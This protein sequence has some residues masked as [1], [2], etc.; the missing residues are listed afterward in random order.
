MDPPPH[1]VV[2]TPQTPTTTLDADSSTINAEGGDIDTVMVVKSSGDP[3]DEETKDWRQL[4]RRSRALTEQEVLAGRVAAR[5]VGRGSSYIFDPVKSSFTARWDCIIAASVLYT[6][7][8]TPAEVAFIHATIRLNWL[9]ICNQIVNLAFIIDLGLQFFTSYQLPNDDW[10]RDHH[11]IAK[12]YLTSTFGFD[13]VAS[14]PYDIFV[15]VEGNAAP[16]L[17]HKVSAARLFRLVRLLK[18]LRLVRSS[19]LLKKY[20]ADLTLSYGFLNVSFFM[21]ISILMAHWIACAWGL[22]GNTA[23]SMENSWLG[24]FIRPDDDKDASP[25]NQWSIHVPKNQ[26]LVALYMSVMTLTTVGY[27]DLNPVNLSEYALLVVCMLVGGFMWAYIIGAVCGT[28]ANLD[29]IRIRHHQRYDQINNLLVNMCIPQHIA[30]DVRAYCFQ[31]EEVE[32]HVAYSSLIDY[33]SPDLQRKVC[34]ELIKSSIG[35]VH[36][37]HNRSMSFQMALYKTLDTRMYCPKETITQRELLV[38][39]NNGCIQAHHTTLVVCLRGD[40]LNLDFV[41]KYQPR[42]VIHMVAQKYTEVNILARAKLEAVCADFPKDRAVILWMRAIYAFRNEFRNHGP[43]LRDR[44]MRC[45]EVPANAQRRPI[46]D[47]RR[48]IDRAR[49]GQLDVCSERLR[50][51]ELVVEEAVRA[52][53]SSFRHASLRL[54]GNPAVVNLALALTGPTAFRDLV[55]P[56]VTGQLKQVLDRFATYLDAERASA[57]PSST[58]LAYV[59]HELA[60]SVLLGGAKTPTTIHIDTQDDFDDAAKAFPSLDA[61]IARCYC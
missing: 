46:D 51:S 50:D 18:L 19:Q 30:R 45:L 17:L 27:G 8:V 49:R 39:V 37:I 43:L 40:V 52:A 53:P 16:K 42:A 29:L 56:H 34:S 47:V 48:A 38:I 13:L 31:T 11:K 32:R 14:F 57:L 22:V 24:K 59:P 21:C 1:T 15:L 10:V 26:Y 3:D 36:Y 20:R 23:G 28:I 44:I 61:S 55:L 4:Y 35:R 60:P 6:A 58:Q 25:P 54:R 5:K 7:L 41:L 33:L 2:S 12:H 9:F